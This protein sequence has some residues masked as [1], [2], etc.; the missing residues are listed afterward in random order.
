MPLSIVEQVLYN[1][2]P[3]DNKLGSIFF[4]I[5]NTRNEYA[6]QTQNYGSKISYDEFQY[7][8]LTSESQY[9]YLM[10]VVEMNV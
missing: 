3:P 6:S 1:V 5:L 7:Y 10:D 4:V 9:G 2:S 8:S